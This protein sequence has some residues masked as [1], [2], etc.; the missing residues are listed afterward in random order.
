MDSS[1]A[2]ADSVADAPFSM[3]VSAVADGAVS[4]ATA[5]VSGASAGVAACSCSDKGKVS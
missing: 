5:P 3:A 1:D 4:V 2:G